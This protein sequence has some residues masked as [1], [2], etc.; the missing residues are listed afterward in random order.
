MHILPKKEKMFGSNVNFRL[1][2]NKC[3]KLCFTVGCAIEWIIIIFNDS[4]HNGYLLILLS[5]YNNICYMVEAI[6]II[7]ISNDQLINQPF[8][9]L[10]SNHSFNLHRGACK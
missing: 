9:R 3:S 1:N 5:S 4:I 6:E 8:D 2:W 7:V 10:T